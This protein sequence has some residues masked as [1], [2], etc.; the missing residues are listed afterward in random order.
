MPEEVVTTVDPQLKAEPAEPAPAVVE[1][2]VVPIEPVVEPVVPVVVDEPTPSEPTEEAKGSEPKKI[3]KELISIRKRA[4]TAE[5]RVRE[6]EAEN[7]VFKGLQPGAQQPAQ[8]PAVAPTGPPA[9]PDPEQFEGGRYSDEYE[10]ELEGYR[11]AKVKYDIKQEQEQ[12]RRLGDQRAQQEAVQK[13][14]R[15]FQERI[16]TAAEEDPEILTIQNDQTLPLSFAMATVL[17]ES[18]VSPK[19]LRYLSDHRDEARAIFDL[20]PSWIDPGTNRIMQRGNPLAAA[21]AIGRLEA[22]LTTAPV[23]PTPKPTPTRI[24]TA[25]PEPVKTVGDHG[26]G[27]PVNQL[28]DSTPTADWI[29]ERNRREAANYRVRR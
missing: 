14:E 9:P 19:L 5:E 15:T 11:V 8:P 27:S 28:D 23:T 24:V 16:D 18:D 1:T 13:I 7:R 20:A 12:E 10:K 17:K 29:K 26:E 3:V 2:P 4:Q 25:A 6:L 21:H 22:K